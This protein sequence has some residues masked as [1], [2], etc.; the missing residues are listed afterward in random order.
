M[1]PFKCRFASITLDFDSYSSVFSR[2]A[3]F[4]SQIAK[5]VAKF[6]YKYV[7]VC[8]CAQVDSMHGSQINLKLYIFFINHQNKFMEFVVHE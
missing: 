2:L 8:E 3:F 4:L 7:D 5:I 1:K 6:A